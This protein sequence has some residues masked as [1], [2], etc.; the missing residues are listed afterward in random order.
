MYL[1]IPERF[2]RGGTGSRGTK[3]EGQVDFLFLVLHSDLGGLPVLS[4][5]FSG[6]PIA[7]PPSTREG[8]GTE[9]DG[10]GSPRTEWVQPV[11]R[12]KLTPAETQKETQLTLL[13]LSKIVCLKR[14][15][16]GS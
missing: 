7:F 12:R 5:W 1:S 2:D 14:I 9:T 4:G 8:K 11:P 6:S 15:K 3:V 13:S 16:F 10:T